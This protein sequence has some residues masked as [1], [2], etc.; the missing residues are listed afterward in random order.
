[1]KKHIKENSFKIFGLGMIS[2]I[3]SSFIS[4]ILFRREASLFTLFLATL[5]VSP[6][7]YKTLQIEEKYDLSAKKEKTMIKHHAGTIRLYM[8]LFSGFILGF[9][10]LNF[11]LPESLTSD[12]FRL[13]ISTL[14][15]AGKQLPFLTETASIFLNNSKVLFAC[16]LLSLIFGTGAMLIF[17]WNAS[18]IAIAISEF[19][20][21]SLGINVLAFGVAGF[22]YKFMLHGIP[23]IIAYIIGGLAGGM[24]ATAIARHDYSSKHFRNIIKDATITAIFAFILLFLAAIIEVLTGI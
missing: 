14:S 6:F 13:Q 18:F 11:W 17:L 2:V 3:V 5:S 19:I 15:P 21:K 16:I 8:N 9:I 24:I 7:V 1:M 23:E 4:L 22:F 20:K 10:I 12:L